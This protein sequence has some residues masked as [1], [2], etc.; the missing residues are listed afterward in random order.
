MGGS[1]AMALKKHKIAKEVIGLSHRQ[2]SLTYALKAKIIDRG[3]TDIPKAVKNSDLVVLATPVDSITKLVASI[4]PHLKRN[5]IVT[6]VGSV[7]GEVV[8]A[9]QEALS[10]PGFFVG[11]H[12]LV[13]SEKKGVTNASI[14][15]FEGAQCIITPTSETNRGACERVRKLWTKIGAK[16]EVLTPQEH[17][18]ALAYISHMPHLLAFGLMDIIPKE[19]LIYATQGLKDTT[20]IASSSAQIWN[21]ICLSNSK[22]TIKALDE[23]IAQLASMRKAI[24]D[25][26]SKTLMKN[27]KKA[28]EKRDTI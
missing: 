27:F 7:K 28:K 19:H 14:D 21:D 1:L 24:V 5:C 11:A 15:L 12:P 18:T 4:N 25:E 10:S 3:E 26:D 13:G 20:R 23:L 6:D 22:N 16:V 2:T 9:A 8:E 17:D